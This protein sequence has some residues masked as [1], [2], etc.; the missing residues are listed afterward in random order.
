[1]KIKKYLVK[2]IKD[3]L[4]QIKQELGENAVI[5][6]TRK[7]RKG[8]LFGIFG[9][10][11]FT[12]V[13]A[14]AE[15]DANVNIRKKNLDNKGDTI[16]NLREI[17]SQNIRK[18]VTSTYE[19]K[20]KENKE[21]WDTYKPND[22]RDNNIREIKE[23]LEV[24]RD[25]TKDIEEIK[26]MFA[27]LDAKIEMLNDGLSK[28]PVKLR[29]LFN[30]MIDQSINKDLA[31][32]I[33]QE[34]KNEK[35]DIEIDDFFNVISE[36]FKNLIRVEIPNIGNG[37]SIFLGPTGVGKTTTLAKLAADLKIKQKKSVAILT[38]DTYRIA[39]VSQL[40]TYSE[41]MNI[42]FFVAYTPE[43]A[44]NIS[45]S[46]KNYDSILIDT[47][48][49]SQKDEIHLEE[50][51]K[52]ISAINPNYKFLLLN[53][54][55][56]LKDSVDIVSRFSV[57]NPTHLIFTKLDETNSYGN[58]LNITSKFN[59][60]IAFVTTGQNVPDDIEKAEARRLSFM[61]SKEV[62]KNV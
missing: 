30:N 32:K 40:K 25:I 22:K 48:G 53:I 38:I 18:N 8:G 15:E 50:L 42:P 11:I 13:T 6:Q 47:A 45:A 36:R 7:I 52:Y 62:L 23:S 59:L 44:R 27:H 3:A 61:I 21:D 49:R 29:K 41:I 12:E 16:Y 24:T 28:Y 58:I 19:D 37:I 34:L 9:G 57:C 2:D 56:N 20:V 5:L 39:A 33:L 31:L 26:Q 4:I 1:M 10:E 14:V 60:P 51:R 54:S 46:L 35:L 43:E 55:V 17:L